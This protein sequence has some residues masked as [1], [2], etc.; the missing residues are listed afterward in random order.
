MSCGPQYMSMEVNITGHACTSTLNI[1]TRH[2]PL[3]LPSS[4]N[5]ETFDF[6]AS[7]T[8]TGRYP[9]QRSCSCLEPSRASGSTRPCSI[10]Y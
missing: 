9:S 1:A 8:E 2:K 4:T 3:A 7:I 6:A 10:G 5:S